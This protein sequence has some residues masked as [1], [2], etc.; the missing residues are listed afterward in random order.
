[1]LRRIGEAT[2]G[3]RVT[4]VPGNH[5]HH[6]ARTL[7]DGAGEL[8]L[9]TTTRRLRA[10]RWPRWRPRSGGEVRVAYPGVWVRPD[11]FA[12]HGHYLDVHNTVP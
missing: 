1:M 2:A 10:A 8:A 4:I 11:V 7:I 5:D 9:E 12:T 6:L 3:K